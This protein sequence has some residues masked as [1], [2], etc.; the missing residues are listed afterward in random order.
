MGSI[1]LEKKYITEYIKSTLTDLKIKTVEVE[2]AKYHHNSNYDD[3]P[4][5]IK[6]GILSPIELNRLGIKKYSDDTLKL[7]NDTESHINGNNAISLSVT[8]LTDIYHNEEVYDPFSPTNVDFL[9][10]SDIP[11]KRSTLH[12][13]NEYLSY[14]K[15]TI[16]KIKALDIRLLTLIEKIEDNKSYYTIESLIKKYNTLKEIA[17]SIK[18]TKLDIPLRENSKTNITLD[19]DKLSTIPKLTLK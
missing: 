1:S 13:G 19:I 3:V 5:I 10:S 8:G 4:F 14:Q 6:H 15:I 11:V 9:I 18:R 12:Y 16:D 7:M 2:N 17:I